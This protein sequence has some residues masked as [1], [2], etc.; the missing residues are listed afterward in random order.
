MRDSYNGKILHVDL[1]EA[2]WWSE[3]LDDIIYRMFL[4][5]SGLSSYLLL[6]DLKPR[7]DPLGPDNLLILM[8]SVINGLPLS[9]AN[10]Y[11]AA[12]ISPLTG[13]FGVSQ[14]GGYW[15]PELKRAGFDGMVVHGRA[16]KPVYL[17]VND[18]ECEIRDASRYWGQLSGEVQDGLEDE[19]GDKRIRVLQTGVAGENR[20]RFAALTNQ[21]RHFHGRAGLGAVMASKNLKAIVVRGRGKIG[22]ADG[23]AAQ[24]VVQWF[25]ETYDRD[26]DALHLNGTGRVVAMLNDAGILPTHNFRDGSFDMADSISGQAMSDTILV[27]RGTCF[28][29]AV[30]CK[31]EVAVPDRGVTPK[32]GGM[33]YETIAATGSLC[34]VGDLE[35]IAEASEWVN[36]YVMDSISTGAVIAFAMECYE[37]GILT[38]DDTDGIE[39]VWG[40]ADAVIQMIH[41]I[42]HRDGIGNLLADG[43]KQAASQ[44][45]GGAE[46]FALHVK[47][48]ELPMHEPR[49]KQGLALA[50]AISPT[51]ADHME[52]PHDPLYEGFG[53]FQ[54]ELSQLGLLEPVDR[55]TL[56]PQKVRAFFY[57]QMVWSLYDAVGMCDFVGAPL[58]ALELNRLRDTINAA[59]G[60]DMSVFELM[61]VGERA[62]TMARLFNNREGFTPADDTL[63]SR[64]FEP[65]GSGAV[66]GQA[67]DR[68][69]FARA[70]QLYYQMAGW[71]EKGVPGPAKLAELGLTRMMA[72][73]EPT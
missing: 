66:A 15:G 9:G 50:Y 38:R 10:R 54:H 35:A 5:G 59:A 32:Y 3:E 70:L 17:F 58:G 6:R 39:L 71:D 56:S 7:V 36:R 8:T 21:L 40:N 23:D 73:S 64:L 68:E 25:G 62:N 49:G 14:A 4:G 12:G 20:V 18:G 60:W 69:E 11:S 44:L 2:R 45:G 22:A 67:L 57:T 72:E 26:T 29:C 34:D 33:E 55:A 46:R 24:E 1:T 31:R 53:N 13:G 47:G 48:Q 19:I 30:A 52:A 37:N 16:E 63:P 65:L 41:K 27:N 28:A 61:K 51:G 42:A 43:V